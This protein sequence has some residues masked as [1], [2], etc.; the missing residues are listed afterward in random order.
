MLSNDIKQLSKALK[1]WAIA[2]DAL[3]AGDTIMLLRKGGIKEKGFQIKSS[4]VWLYPTYE[5]Q[6]PELLKSKYALSA[7]PVASG[8]HPATVTIKSCAEIT[9][10]FP[11]DDETQIKALLPYHVWNEQMI[12]DRLKWKPRQPIVV[13]LLRVY[14]LP[15]FKVIPYSD[16]YGGCKSWI[17]LAETIPTEELIPVIEDD[18]YAGQVKEIEQIILNK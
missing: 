16:N 8:W 1:E 17:E 10:I 2:V 12:S 13:L 4:H 18:R 5:H 7:T 6:K 14:R 15:E 11:V 3:T 9:N